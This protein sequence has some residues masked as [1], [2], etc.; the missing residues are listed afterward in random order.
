MQMKMRV[1]GL[2]VRLGKIKRA[3]SFVWSVK[4]S[5]WFYEMGFNFDRGRYFHGSCVRSVS[6]SP[7]SGF[8]D[9]RGEDSG[10]FCF[11]ADRSCLHGSVDRFGG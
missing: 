1:A 2:E 9:F 10:G 5:L 7:S 4:E 11:S 8:Y 6:W 3:E